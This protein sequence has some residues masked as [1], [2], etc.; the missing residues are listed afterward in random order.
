M[1]AKKKQSTSSSPSLKTA[2][3]RCN[4]IQVVIWLVVAQS[5]GP[6]LMALTQHR[7]CCVVLGAFQMRTNFYY[8]LHLW[9][10]SSSLCTS[11]PSTP[12]PP[13][14]RRR[15]Y[16]IP[17]HTFPVVFVLSHNTTMPTSIRRN[18]YVHFEF[19]SPSV[20]CFTTVLASRPVKAILQQCWLPDRRA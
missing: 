20:Y 11:S 6:V 18:V 8:L 10:S 9:S 14:L 19:A 4:K 1:N 13:P 7:L 16:D 17:R 2:E 3:F 12:P 5:S 15:H